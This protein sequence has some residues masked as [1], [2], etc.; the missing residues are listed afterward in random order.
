[1]AGVRQTLKWQNNDMDSLRKK[2]N[3]IKLYDY[4]K[5]KV[6]PACIPLAGL[7]CKLQPDTTSLYTS[8]KP[9]NN[10][11]KPGKAVYTATI[12]TNPQS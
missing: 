10:T 2:T 3:G 6:S 8:M 5:P 7:P 9:S 11:D 12:I 1:M 4:Q